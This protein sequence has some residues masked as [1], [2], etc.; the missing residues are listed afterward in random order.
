MSKYILI[1]SCSGQDKKAVEAYKIMFPDAPIPE[2]VR[3][4]DRIN[5]LYLKTNNDHIKAISRLNGKYAYY[6]EMEGGTIT[7]EYNLTNGR[8][9]A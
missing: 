3:G 8:R 7:K 4:R 6:V 1:C 9:V 2:V 5:Q